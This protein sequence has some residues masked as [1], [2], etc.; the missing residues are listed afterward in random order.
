M[1]RTVNPEANEMPPLSDASG[2]FYLKGR[3]ILELKRA[4]GNYCQ[5]NVRKL[6]VK[7]SNTTIMIQS[8]PYVLLLD[9][10]AK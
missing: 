3:D 5:L 2:I 1:R 9:P 7:S 8:E 10:F 6:F 4:V